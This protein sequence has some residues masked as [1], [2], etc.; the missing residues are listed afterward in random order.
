MSAIHALA[1]AAAGLPVIAVASRTAERS[2]ERAAQLGAEACAYRELPAGAD[3]VVVAT[4]PAQHVPQALA[5]VQAGVAVLVETPVATT[6]A[7]ADD[8]VAAGAAGATVLYGE[9]LAFAPV[10]ARAVA[11]ARTMGPLGDIEVR[12]LSPRPDRGGAGTAEWGG[13]ALFDLGVHAVAVALLLAGDDEPVEV[14]ALLTPGADPAVD[15]RAEVRV[16]FTSG[17]QA[18]VEAAWRHQDTL[19]DLQASSATGVVRA[20]L[21]PIVALEH[22]GEPVAVPATTT[23]AGLD[24]KVADLG[25]VAQMQTLG[26]AVADGS[27]PAGAPDAAFGRRV[28]DVVCGAYASAGSGGPVPLPFAGPRDRTPLELWRG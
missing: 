28:L 24:P 20:D 6:L 1:A 27:L 2:Q 10:V 22:D 18:R 9:S 16:R 19:W 8:L 23:P 7:A 11:A 5:A 15:D 26:R 17:L 21:L 13:G 25:Y 4:P 12:A 14:T 3:A